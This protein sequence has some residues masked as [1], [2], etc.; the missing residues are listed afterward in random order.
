MSVRHRLQ[1]TEH[2]GLFDLVRARKVWC[3]SAGDV[4]VKDTHPLIVAS[5]FGVADYFYNGLI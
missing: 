3:P 4:S 5:G 1:L 2:Q